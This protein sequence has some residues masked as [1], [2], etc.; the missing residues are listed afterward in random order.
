MKYKIGDKFPVKWDKTLWEEDG[1]CWISGTVIIEERKVAVD[2]GISVIFSSVIDIPSLPDRGRLEII[3]VDGEE[4]C[5]LIAPEE[6]KDPE[7]K[8]SGFIFS[9]DLEDK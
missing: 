9:E 3:E 7:I 8:A 2:I 1:D 5:Y 6:W 4:S